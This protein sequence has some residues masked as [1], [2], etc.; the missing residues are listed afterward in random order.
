MTGPAVK[1]PQQAVYYRPATDP[2]RRCDACV[3]YQDRAC[4][5]VEGP[6]DP[7]GTCDIFYPADLIQAA[8]EAY[9]SGW[10]LTNAPWTS[11]VHAGCLAAVANGQPGDTAAWAGSAIK[12]SAGIIAKE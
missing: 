12:I 9:L 5:R 7:G 3:M 1:V 10:A 2:A 8:A 11:R 4:T 6:I